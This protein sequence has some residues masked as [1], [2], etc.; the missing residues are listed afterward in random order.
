[1]TGRVVSRK[2]VSDAFY[3]LG[4]K[5]GDTLLIHTSLKSFGKLENGA[6]TVIQGIEDVLGKDGTLIV[7]TLCQEDFLNSYK[8]WHLDK[9]SDVGYLTEYFRKL[10]SVL[11]SDHATHSVAARGRY[12]YEYTFEHGARGRRACPF[13]EYAFADSSPWYKMIKNHTYTAFLG[14]DMT[15]FTVKHLVEGELIETLL[16]GIKDEEK[17]K[18]MRDKLMTFETFGQGIWPFYSSKEMQNVLEKKGMISHTLCGS[19]HI[20]AVKTK[21]AFETSLNELLTSPEKWFSGEPLKWIEEAVSL[22]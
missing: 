12:A 16:K 2:D 22:S 15:Y 7:P 11:R 4:I 1:M 21:E 10:P 17:R 13:G 14:V 3:D 20:I 19:S 5:G 18:L 9:K 8:T 6:E